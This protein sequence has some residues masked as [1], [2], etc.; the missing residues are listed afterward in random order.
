MIKILFVLLFVIFANA[1]SQVAYKYYPVQSGTTN[2]LRDIGAL[3]TS[4]P[5]LYYICGNNGTLL[6]IAGADS[7]CRNV[8]AGVSFNLNSFFRFAGTYLY[9]AMFFAD[10]GMLLCTSNSGGNW[11]QKNTGFPSSL[12]S[13]VY[14]KAGWPSNY[15]TIAVGNNGTIIYRKY[16]PT[17]DSAWRIVQSGTSSDLKSIYSY[18][19]FEKIYIAGSSGR[20]LK[21][22]DTGNTW[23]VLNSGTSNNLNSIFFRTQDTGFV[24]GDGGIILRTI[25]G[26]LNW[27]QKYSGTFQNLNCIAKYNDTTMFIAGDKVVLISNNR[28]ENWSIDTAAPK[29]NFNSVNFLYS[30]KFKANVPVFAGD[31]GKIYKKTLDTTYH[32]NIDVKLDGNNISAYFN[33]SGVFDQDFRYQNSCGFEW[34]KGSNKY[35]IFTAGFC[36]SAFY[37][38]QLRQA[39]ASYKG[40]YVKG[41]CEYGV[42]KKGSEFKYYKICRGDSYLNSWDWA[43]WGL[44][45]PY[46][47]PFVDANANGRYEPEID[48]PGVK[49]AVQTIFYCMTDAD[50]S[51]HNGGEGFG[52]GTKP[53]YA[54]VH[55]T[56][57]VYD[58]P[59]LQDVQFINYSVINKGNYSWTRTHMSIFSDADLGEALDD[60]SGCDTSLKLTFC[61]NADNNDPIYGANPPAV[62]FMLLNSPTVKYGTTNFPLGMTSSISYYKNISSC[63]NDPNGEPYCAHLMFSGYKKDSTCFLDPTFTPYRKTKYTYS[64]DPETNTGWTR[65]RGYVN[66]CNHDST[67]TLYVPCAPA[68]IRVMLNSGA[69]DLTVAPG[70]TQR[71]VVAQL[72]ARG[73]SNLNSVTELKNLCRSVRTFYEQ[74]FPFVITPTPVII[75]P[76]SFL[77]EQNYPNPFNASTRI[78]FHVPKINGSETGTVRV[79]MKVYDLLGRVV[80]TLINGDYSAQDYEVIFDGKN[81]ASGMYFYKLSTN[82]YTSVKRMVLIK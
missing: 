53:L 63:E 11:Y 77:L 17:N 67:G 14:I 74:N 49:N 60:Y 25:N 7:N 13:G 56:A 16:F 79:V 68:D 28:G 72:I 55:L 21:S 70:D 50:S 37:N 64:G 4:N 44:M 40:E 12:N 29:Y 36:I 15:R 26:G 38:N 22:I 75:Y 33:R 46:G 73:T 20:I 3:K 51:F 65:L 45:V 57:W 34:P 41:Y 66:N 5:Y 48:T 18:N 10:N 52:A 8:Q 6:S 80:Q 61:Y 54:E 81:L 19:F 32:P 35:A 76:T 43:N 23:T 30:P 58:T 9:P 42:Y 39:I 27:T 71:F 82:D 31:S 78:K 62:G 1:G 24:V 59:G 69:E 2:D 47:A